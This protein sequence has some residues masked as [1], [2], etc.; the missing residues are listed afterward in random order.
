VLL[1]AACLVVEQEGQPVKSYLSPGGDR[2][3]A[4]EAGAS[5]DITLSSEAQPGVLVEPPI[6]LPAWGQP[7]R[8]R[9]EL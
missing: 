5:Y 3:F 1:D 9:S 4:T 6:T 7:V 2:S 8:L